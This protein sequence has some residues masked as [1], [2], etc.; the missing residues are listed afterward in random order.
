[1]AYTPAV[2]SARRSRPNAPRPGA[3]TTL[4]LRM[5][6]SVAPVCSCSSKARL[7][8][9]H[10]PFAAQARSPPGGGRILMPSGTTDLQPGDTIVGLTRA[11]Q[12]P[13]L[14]SALLGEP[15]A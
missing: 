12:V 11:D 9:P 1:M 13:A 10:R 5:T 3:S 7:S 15:T 2:P 8:F 14:R 4:C 6:R